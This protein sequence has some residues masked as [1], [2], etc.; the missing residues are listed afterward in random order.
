MTK[1]GVKCVHVWMYN[2]FKYWCNSERL[3]ANLW[4]ND[5]V[6]KNSHILCINIIIIISSIS[7]LKKVAECN[8]WHKIRSERGSI[9]YTSARENRIWNAIP[10]ALFW[11]RISGMVFQR[12]LSQKCPW[13]LFIFDYV[14]FQRRLYSQFFEQKRLKKKIETIQYQFHTVKFY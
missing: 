13:L 14:G 9:S 5:S 3:Y 11:Q 8:E 1:V 12:I 2:F 10:A 4:R 7:L 6:K